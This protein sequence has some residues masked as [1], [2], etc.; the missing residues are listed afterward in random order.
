MELTLK[1]VTVKVIGKARFF[2]LLYSHHD[3]FGFELTF[4][5]PKKKTFAK[6]YAVSKNCNKLF[7]FT[8]F[9]HLAVDKSHSTR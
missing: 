9:F 1:M 3:S 8:F 7:Q 2:S 4:D 5:F 6:D